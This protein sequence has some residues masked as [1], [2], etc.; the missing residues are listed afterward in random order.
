MQKTIDV[1]SL[2]VTDASGKMPYRSRK[3]EQ[4]TAIS[5]GQRKLIIGEIEF[6]LYFWNPKTLPNPTVVY[7]G[8]SPGSHIPL[9]S[10]MFESVAAWHLY[11][12]R[13]FKIQGTSKIHLHQQLFT[14][15]DAK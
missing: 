12:P 5:W 6:F 15:K 2:F 1:S 11:D 7:V 10:S 4:R 13:P 8:A 9:L 3:G 14:D